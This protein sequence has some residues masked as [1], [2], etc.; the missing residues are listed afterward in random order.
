MSD[1]R[2]QFI[3]EVETALVVKYGADQ[4]AVITDMVAKVLNNY[5]IMER[6]TDLIPQDDRNE[7]LLKRYSACL[8]VDGKS[9]K[10]IYQ[11]MWTLK[12]LSEVIQK[13]FAEMGAYDIRFYF[14][15]EKER[16]ISNRTLENHRSYISAF[17]QWMT[18]EEIIVKNP[19]TKVKRIKCPVEIKK[20]FSEVEIDAIRGACA[21]LRERALI[22][23]LLSTGVRVAELTEMEI[24]DIN[25]STLAVHVIHGK[26]AKERITYITAVALKHLLA[27]INARPGDCQ[28]LFC[29]YKAE[30]IGVTGIQY[31]LAEIGKR[32]GVENVHP[33]RF[34]RTLATFLAKRGMPIQEIQKLLGHSDISTTMRYV[35]VEDEKVQASHRRY[36]A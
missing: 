36:I 13:P 10:T 8:M 2:L 23:V 30:P 26:G 24:K 28:A 29:N 18:N 11:Y 20:P 35:C 1:Y 9:K 21:N 22:E 19:I 3:Q 33:H 12:R 14:A 32:A 17:F 7:R 16:G 25:Q 34:R 27:Y 6:C 4:S 15:I 31:I 5:E